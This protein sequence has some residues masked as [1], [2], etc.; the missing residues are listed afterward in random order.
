MRIKKITNI[1]KSILHLDIYIKKTWHGN[2]YGGF[3]VADDFLNH[4]SVVYS[5]GVGEDIS[6]D[7]SLK[8]KY[9]CS[10][11]LFDPT[12]KSAHWLMSQKDCSDYIFSKVGLAK[13]SG[14]REFFLPCND[15][16]VSGSLTSRPELKSKSIDC[17][18]SSLMDIM[19]TFG[20]GEIDLLKMD[21]EGEEYEVLR[22][23]LDKGVKIGQ[24]IVEF[25]DRFISTTD[26]SKDVIKEMRKKGY[27]CFGI[28]ESFQE[29][30]FIHESLRM[31]KK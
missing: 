6:F 26:N 23:L 28:S 16:H 20:H 3:Y 14:I 7:R 15:K 13:K 29:M 19:K 30:S 25:H 17:E 24:I 11:Y 9:G 31:V 21:I 22:D 8:T 10:I 5:F 18:F 4:D 2:S 27:Q 12:P 1:V